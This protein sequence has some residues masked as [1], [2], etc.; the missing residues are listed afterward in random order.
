M[1][2]LFKSLPQLSHLYFTT[3][4]LRVPAQGSPSTLLSARSTQL[5]FPSQVFR[6][7]AVELAALQ[8]VLY[9]RMSLH[10]RL[11]SR[12]QFAFKMLIFLP[13]L[14]VKVAF[15]YSRIVKDLGF[16]ITKNQKTR[17]QS[18]NLFIIG[19]LW[20]KTY[21]LLANKTVNSMFNSVRLF[22]HKILDPLASRQSRV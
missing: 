15:L 11:F 8:F 3:R 1:S 9:M 18:F 16:S 17:K 13:L 2:L 6:T 20:L 4:Y 19:L 10:T 21:F 5:V 22:L 12:P 14:Q 7:T